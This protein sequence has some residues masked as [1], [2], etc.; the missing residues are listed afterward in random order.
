MMV[1]YSL[2]IG[3]WELCKFVYRGCWRSLVFSFQCAQTSLL[4]E[5]NLIIVVLPAV[6]PLG[7]WVLTSNVCPGSRRW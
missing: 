6:M 5:G 7:C 3:I 2:V 4:Y 1:P